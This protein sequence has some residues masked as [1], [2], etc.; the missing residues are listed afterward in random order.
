[1]YARER[2]LKSWDGETEHTRCRTRQS[3]TFAHH[4]RD[5]VPQKSLAASGEKNDV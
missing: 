3:P 2:K 5:R 1:M 4:C